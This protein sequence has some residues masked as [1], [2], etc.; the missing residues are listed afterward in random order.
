VKKIKN[1]L[2][3]ILCIVLVVTG[4]VF[5][6]NKY[7][8]NKYGKPDPEQIT[9]YTDLNQYHTNIEDVDVE[10]VDRGTFQGF[11]LSP[12]NRQYKGIIIC[13]GGSE[14]SPAFDVA[15]QYAREGY[16]TLAVFMFGMKNQQ[17]TLTKIPLEQFEDV[18]RYTDEIEESYPI[19]VWA[20]SKGS[21]YALYLASKY[22]E[23]SNLILVAPSAYSF[24]GLDFENPGASWTWENEEVPC[25][26]IQ[27][28]PVSV[29]FKSMV[30]PMIVGEPVSFRE[31]YEAAINADSDKD[32]KLIPVQDIKADILLIA[33]TDDQMWGSYEMAGIIKEIN[34]NAKICSYENAGHVFKGNGISNQPGM[35]MRL[36]GTEEGNKAAAE[37]SEKEINDF[38][39][40]HHSK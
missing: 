9:D 8:D 27:K 7:N 3:I 20:A 22:D 28:T 1:I 38:L 14:G 16:E 18:L 26:D 15:E 33:G 21:E 23:I 17:K 10:Y 24:S 19:T 31:I 12:K 35:R 37:Q 2:L 36:G 13:Y 4:T 25:I 40:K 30:F 6:I 39:K 11:H 5:C 32:D 34:D 29:T